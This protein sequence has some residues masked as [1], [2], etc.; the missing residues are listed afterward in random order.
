MLD[1]R[2]DAVK[3]SKTVFKFPVAEQH[4]QFQGQLPEIGTVSVVLIQ[5]RKYLKQ[6]L[7]GKDLMM[8]QVLKV[9]PLQASS[10]QGIIG[11]PGQGEYLK[12][13]GLFRGYMG[14]I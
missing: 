6:I 14:F 13:A 1:L 8:G 10:G 4:C 7:A 5:V 2:F 12:F 9:A 11:M 3:L